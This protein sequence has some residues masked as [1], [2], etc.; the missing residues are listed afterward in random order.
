MSDRLR[1]GVVGLGRLWEARHRPALLTRRDRFEVVTL[2]D[3]VFQRAEREARKFDIVPA[4]SLTEAI[5]HPAVEAIFVLAPQWFGLHSVA[6]ACT[7]RKAVYCALA[8]DLHADEL[9]TLAEP[10]RKAGIL[11]VPEM[12]RRFYPATLR[13]RELL[14]TNLGPPRLIL[15]QARL[16]GYDRYSEPGPSTQLADGPLL[17]DPGCNLIDWCRFVF[18]QEPQRVFGFSRTVLTSASADSP[19]DFEGMRL[20]FAGGAGAHIFVGRYH[21]EAWGDALQFLPP[22]GFQVF[23][24]RGVAWIEMP[25]RIRWSDDTGIYDERLP[26]A[27]SVGELLG[28]HFVRAV[29]GK[30]TLAPNL[31]DALATRRWLYTLRAAQ[32]A[33]DS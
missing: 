6:L 30:P 32:Q 31:D 29:R 1:I 5:A 14:A 26:L 18:Q 2:Y 27:S 10:I 33:H 23:A 17:F 8:W 7:H 22:P 9:E 15:G 4:Q 20:D 12:P 28:D 21:H 3:Q 11:F 24:E 13:L 19:A 16:F 25:D